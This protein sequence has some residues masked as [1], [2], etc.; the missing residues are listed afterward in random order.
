MPSFGIADPAPIADR[1]C[2]EGIMTS[3]DPS[4]S[5]P[6]TRQHLT[7]PLTSHPVVPAQPSTSVPAPR[8]CEAPVVQPGR[9]SVLSRVRAWM[10]VLPVDAVLLAAPVLWAPQQWRAHVTMTLL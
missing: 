8:S 5:T 6:S 9:D 3:V 4:T 1:T 2:S 7:A 10:L